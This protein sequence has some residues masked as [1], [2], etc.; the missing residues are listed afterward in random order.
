MPEVAAPSASRTSEVQGLGFKVLSSG[1]RV[2]G[3]GF[4][5][6]DFGFRVQGFGLKVGEFPYWDRSS[7]KENSCASV[8]FTY[9]YI[10]R[11]NMSENLP[12]WGGS[13]SSGLAGGGD[14]NCWQTT[15]FHTL[16]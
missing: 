10:T 14:L 13:G 11:K 6:L 3:L 12:G 4:G 7:N 9:M 15:G 2:L 8:G 1:F 16:S 5:V